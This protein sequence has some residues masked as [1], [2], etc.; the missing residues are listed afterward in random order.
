MQRFFLISIAVL[1]L[2]LPQVGGAADLD[3]D[4]DGLSDLLEAKFKTDIVNPDSDSDGYVDGLEIN[5]GYDPLKGDGA[6]LK[7]RIEVNV[8]TQKLHYFLGEVNMGEYPVSTGKTST[9][10]PKGSFIIK[11]KALRP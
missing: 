11:N 5:H 8:K 6:K 1:L 2:S 7:K 9:P 4:S 3:A 10:T